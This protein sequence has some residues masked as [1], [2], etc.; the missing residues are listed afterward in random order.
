MPGPAVTLCPVL[1]LLATPC[2]P[3][4]LFFFSSFSLPLNTA[5]FCAF[6]LPPPPL[7]PPR[8]S[9][10]LS[11]ISPYI[12]H[13]SRDSSVK[14]GT[15]LDILASPR[16]L[17]AR[18][19]NFALLAHLITT[20]ANIMQYQYAGN[21]ETMYAVVLAEHRLEWLVT[22][23]H[24]TATSG[25][26][27]AVRKAQGRAADAS[28]IA[29]GVL[30]PAGEAGPRAE[31]ASAAGDAGQKGDDAASGAIPASPAEPQAQATA[32]VAAPALDAKGGQP[33]AQ[34]AG[35]PDEDG[36]EEDEGFPGR[37]DDVV[38]EEWKPTKEWLDEQMEQIPLLHTVLSGTRYMSTILRRVS[39]K[40]KDEGITT[41]EETFIATL[42]RAT[43]VGVV[44]R[45]H[46]LYTRRSEQ[47]QATWKWLSTFV[48][49]VIFLRGVNQLP[50]FD[51]RGI[52]LFHL[53]IV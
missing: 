3:E 10:T 14:I 44:P 35:A 15:L 24:S 4:W 50:L 22:V 23:S 18:P 52:R 41:D 1:G 43:L 28:G 16:F 26:A 11:N 8:A 27:L 5:L 34:H 51:T 31:A 7:P 47:T 36:D 21:E 6:P 32:A 17:F 9:Q 48:W 29:V 45:P 13:L 12:K 30:E 46:T 53:Q 39:Q 49:G 19:D 2:H 42:R 20:L 25:H 38:W 37:A 40:Q 33:A